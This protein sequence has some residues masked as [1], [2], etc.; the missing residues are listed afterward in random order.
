M[1]SRKPLAPTGANRRG[2]DCPTDLQQVW[3]RIDGMAAANDDVVVL[4]T[5][6]VAH[7]LRTTRGTI[8]EMA[9]VGSIPC[10][11][12]GRAYRF[13][14][15]AVLEWLRAKGRVIPSRRNG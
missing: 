5:A 8:Y 4:D 14:R 15:L 3:E 12:V 11:K 7:L 9:Q 13:E 10:R 6:E 2:L 1:K